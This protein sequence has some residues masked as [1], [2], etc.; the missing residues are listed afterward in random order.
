MHIFDGKFIDR[1]QLNSSDS[2]RFQVRNFFDHAQV[3]TTSFDLGCF[4]VGETF[5]MHLVNHRFA[6]IVAHMTIAFPIKLIIDN[7]AL[8]WTNHAISSGLKL[9]S[10]CLRIRID[11]ACRRIK[12]VPILGVPGS[13]CLKMIKL[14][15]RERRH[16]QTPNITPAIRIPIKTDHLRGF[17]V[18]HFVVKQQPHR[19]CRSTE[20]RKLCAGVV[21][22]GTER[23]LIRELQTWARLA[24]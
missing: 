19:S 22:A 17:G 12:P 21:D 11:Q 23:R 10:E 20:D 24:H 9:A 13:A 16:V 6:D 8:G 2:K 3:T 18:T 15:M 7:D 1:H 14:T 5:D 4:A